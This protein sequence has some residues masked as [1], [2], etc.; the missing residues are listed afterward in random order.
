M[1]LS[2]ALACLL[3]LVGC[4]GPHSTGA[5][6]A[7][8]NLEQELVI[9][10]QSDAE[11]AALRHAYELTLADEALTAERGRIDLALHDCPGPARKSLELSAGDKVRD[12]IR[13]RMGDEAP[14]LAAVAQVALA[15]WRLRR[16]QATAE[17][18]FCDDARE[19]L[20]GSA[21]PESNAGDLL[22]GLGSA[23]VT[24]DPRSAPFVADQAATTLS[25]SNYALGYVDTIRA[26]APLPQYLA[27]V[28]GGVLVDVDTPPRLNIWVPSPTENAG[29]REGAV[30]V[31]APLYP[32]WEPDAIYAA[33][34]GA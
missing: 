3:L 1:R 26:R 2:L 8:Q 7:Q 12:V 32:Q 15:D 27:A 28:Y 23:T 16:A 34:R 14:R 25:L 17:T 19:A 4:V 24:R 22:A 30:D 18:R 29:T 13:V 9:G 6:W 10:R 20:G 21:R 11:R 33:L 5:L 31:L